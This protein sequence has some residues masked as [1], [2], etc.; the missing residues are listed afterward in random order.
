MNMMPHVD[1][2]SFMVG[3]LDSLRDEWRVGD[4]RLYEIGLH[5]R[6]NAF[7]EWRPIIYPGDSASLQREARQFSDDLNVQGAFFYMLCTGCRI[8]EFVVRS[9]IELP[10]GAVTFGERLHLYKCPVVDSGSTV[11]P[12]TFVYDGWFDLERVDAEYLKSAIATIGVALNRMAFAYNGSV[13]WR[14]KYRMTEGARAVATPT[15]EDLHVLDALLRKF[16]TSP[17]A[18]VLDT[19]IDWYQRGLSSR[20]TFTAFL[21]FYV[22]IETIVKAIVEG[23]GD[24]GLA[25]AVASKPDQPQQRLEC[26]RRKH[27]EL[28]ES[29]P[30]RFVREAYFDCEVGVIERI[31]RVTKLVFGEDHQY[32]STLF[33]KRGGYS[34]TD[35]RGHVAHGGLS[36]LSPEDV[37]L[38]GGR[39]HEVRTIASDFLMRVIFRLRPTDRIP[40]WSGQHRVAFSMADP[41]ST[42]VATH[43]TIL[44]TK[45]WRI[46]PEWC[47]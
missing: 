21:C 25:F 12:N 16:P 3:E 31:R 10:L 11:A 44:P 14:L 37:E 40:N 28:Y 18:I 1:G 32:L 17:Q 36:Q 27:D 4:K 2:V 6:Y 15:E 23:E 19:A 9:T 45:D 26:I 24:F 39:L 42:L 29:D 30:R 5:G 13:D 47:D 35:I 41:R 7:G 20:N 34:L 43:E 8:I 38:V 46:R 22:S 33:E